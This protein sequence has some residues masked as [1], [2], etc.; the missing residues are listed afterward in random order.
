LSASLWDE[1][2][3]EIEAALDA[4]RFDAKPLPV[5]LAS[6]SPAQCERF[7]QWCDRNQLTLYLARAVNLPEPL[8]TEAEQRRS[9]NS[10]RVK[11]MCQAYGEIAGALRSARAEFLVLK[12]FTQWERY[13]AEP[14]ARVQ[15]DFDLYCPPDS[16]D[17]AR[18][19][20]EGLGYQPLRQMEEFP[21]DHLP[22]MVRKTGWEWRGD[23]FDPDI[24]FSVD[25]HF[26]F[27]DERTESMAAPGTDAF[28][29]RRE[30][31]RFAGLGDLEICS[32]APADGLAYTC[33]H[34]LRHLLRSSVRPAHVYELAWFLHHN[35]G[36]EVLWSD[37]QRLHPPRLRLLQAI[38][39]RLAEDWFGCRLS[40]AARREVDALPEPVSRWFSSFSASPLSAQF[41]PRKDEL[42]LHL[43]LLETAGQKAAVA[44]RRLLPARFPGP[45]DAV[46]IP[47]ERMTARLRWRSRARYLS[48]ICSR[49]GHHALALAP[50]LWR[51][52]RWNARSWG[53]SGGY[54]T[55]L[56][57][58]FL[59]N[60]GVFTIVL[61]YNLYLV[62]LGFRE[63][64]IGRIAAAHTSGSVAGILPAAWVM[65]RLGPRNTMALCFAGVAVMSTLRATLTAE[66]AL[67]A[68]A[69]LAGFALSIW[70]VVLSPAITQL[71]TAGT[72]TLGFSLFFATGIG[73]GV[74]GGLLGG[75]LPGWLHHSKQQALFVGCGLTALAL[76]PLSRLAIE[77][78][79]QAAK[80]I[81]PRERFVPRF[82]GALA[83]WNL[84]TGAFNPFFNTFFARIGTPVERIGVI[85]STG[86]M[87][88]VAALLLSPLVLRRFGT[89]PG[90]AMMQAATGAALAC[91]AWLPPGPGPPAAYAA[92]M[93]CQYM[94]EPGMYALLMDRVAPEARGGASALNALVNF[95]V[96]ALMAAAA[97]TAFARFGYPPVLT[98]AAGI[99]LAAALL[100]RALPGKADGR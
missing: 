47:E 74:L 16:L 18:R 11:R 2:P 23:Y 77:R 38:A 62:D 68:C 3:R 54:W 20:L 36:D 76:L 27:W 66:P 7:L 87:A 85:Y 15:Y 39:F 55:F 96:Q 14:D 52:L 67:I 24:P 60:L 56:A 29:Q 63:D 58:S 71:T 51:G 98:A 97:G 22:V 100:F 75:K 61:L 17:A 99:A 42:W 4:L 49:A 37:W 28:W 10:K 5:A 78:A 50:T 83:V 6:L 91:L 8:K 9:S 84:A 40:G 13:V 12:G 33:L 43:S 94:S 88:Q 30:P 93:A 70:P 21:T 53:L 44:V 57:S 31:R 72:S 82:L 81:W 46:L 65:R 32:L 69:A 25:V 35:S 1:V 19:A 73:T 90:I 48:Y 59:F 89:L 45:V 64:A 86:Q 92:Y 26:R 79:G 80:T 34:L 41:H 95:A